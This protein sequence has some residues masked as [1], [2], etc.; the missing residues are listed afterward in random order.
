MSLLTI[1]AYEVDEY[2]VVVKNNTS[3]QTY[4]DN[5]EDWNTYTDISLKITRINES[6]P[7]LELDIT[8]DFAYMFDCTGL[9]V[10]FTDFG[11]D[12]F[13]GYDY[14]VDWAY[15]FTVTYTYAGTEYSTSYSVGFH[16]LI[17]RVVR[18][19]AVQANWKDYLRC[20]CNCAKYDTVTRK[21]D[22]FYLMRCAS[23]LCLIDEWHELMLALYK[24][25]GTTH[26]FDT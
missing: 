18:Q 24:L 13:N 14:F 1:C 15:T 7:A 22:Y 10:N 6:T 25:T 17:S 2:E 12:T 20:S 11:E 8:S 21:M 19:Q 3:Q 26:E 23:E 9:H 5:S 4:D 16:N